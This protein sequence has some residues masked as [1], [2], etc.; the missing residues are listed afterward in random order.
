MAFSRSL[1]KDC[2]LQQKWH[3]NLSLSNWENCLL[4]RVRTVDLLIK[5]FIYMK[6]SPGSTF[7]IKSILIMHSLVCLLISLILV[8][9]LFYL[10]L[11]FHWVLLYCYVKDQALSSWYILIKIKAHYFEAH[12]LIKQVFSASMAIRSFCS[13][14]LMFVATMV[15]Y[16]SYWVCFD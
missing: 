12:F 11:A 10:F 4:F 13:K 3:D 6:T 15:T 8:S 7:H 16:S 2:V 14:K 9:L 1:E 5:D